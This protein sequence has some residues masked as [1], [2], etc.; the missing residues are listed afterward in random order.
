MMAICIFLLDKSRKYK[1]VRRCERARCTRSPRCAGETHEK[2]APPDGST[3]L[4]GPRNECDSA[5]LKKKS[6]S[7]GKKKEMAKPLSSVLY[8]DAGSASAARARK[9]AARQR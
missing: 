2:T 8:V 5:S 3:S 7:S 6:A 4:P 1:R 9:R